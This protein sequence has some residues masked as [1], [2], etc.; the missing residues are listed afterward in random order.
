MYIFG[1]IV[2]SGKETNL[3]KDYTSPDERNGDDMFWIED[4]H[5]YVLTVDYVKLNTGI[6]Y[7]AEFPG[8]GQYKL[9][10]NSDKLF[11]YMQTN[12]SKDNYYITEWRIAWMKHYRTGIRKALLAMAVYGDNSGDQ[13][14]DEHGIDTNNNAFIG[15]E[16]LRGR[17]EIS[18]NV[19][20]ILKSPNYDLM[21]NGEYIGVYIN[22]EDF[23]N[24]Y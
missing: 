5:R 13:V 6:D 21:Y 8:Q 11:N 4:E 17:V 1:D 9:N 15:I 19:E 7:E 24:D 12:M 18:A 14:G 3:G 20:R 10:E 16:N 22:S 23:R 2:V